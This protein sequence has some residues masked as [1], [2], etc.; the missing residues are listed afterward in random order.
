MMLRNDFNSIEITENRNVRMLLDCF[1][2]AGLDF[3]P[4][5]IL[6]MQNT[7]FRVSAFFVKIKFPVFLFIEIDSPFD[8]FFNLGRSIL[9][10]FFN[11]SRIT[12]PVTR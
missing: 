7:E 8:Q 3:S 2:Q 5:I 6:V 12:D 9:N 10:Y 1:N 11:S 4:C